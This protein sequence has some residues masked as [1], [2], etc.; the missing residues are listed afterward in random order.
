[1][2]ASLVFV[3]L[4]LCAAWAAS[5][6]QANAQP[7]AQRRPLDITHDE[8]GPVQFRLSEIEHL[9]RTHRTVR[10]LGH[11]QSSCTYYL[12]LPPD[13]VCVSPSAHLLFHAVRDA[14]TQTLL[15]DWTETAHHGFSPRLRAFLTQLGFS[16]SSKQDFEVSGAQLGDLVSTC[17]ENHA[18]QP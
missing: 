11:C 8:G 16:A 14:Y 10:I 6:G 2:R 13:Q 17:G 15:P 1:M 3:A 7:A 5:N 12:Q 9:R 18:S 4:L